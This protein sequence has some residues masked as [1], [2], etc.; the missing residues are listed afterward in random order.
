MKEDLEEKQTPEEL[1]DDMSFLGGN[2]DVSKYDKYYFAKLHTKKGE[3]PEFKFRRIVDGVTIDVKGATQTI[4]GKLNKITFSQYEYEKTTLKTVRFN[5]ETLNE[6]G[7]LVGISWG[8][9]WNSVL[10][11]LVNS[12]L[13]ET[14]SVDSLLVSVY[15]DQKSGYNKAMFRINGKKP[16]WKYT[17]DQMNEKKE[18]IFNKKGEL[19]KTETGELIDFLESELQN[20]LT[21]ILPN[22][23]PEDEVQKNVVNIVEQSIEDV[24][25]SQNDQDIDEFLNIGEEDE[26]VVDKKKKK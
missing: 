21:V 25:P 26:P 8:C 4:S 22:F 13:N 9:G 17:I 3:T 23:H 12:L 1:N 20:H 11:N 7:K 6:D 5:L 15:T 10:I 19:V 14:K 2:K 18:K 24:I 16:E